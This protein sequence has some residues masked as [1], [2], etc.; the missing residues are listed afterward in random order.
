[1]KY[2]AG[3]EYSVE[4]CSSRWAL[5]PLLTDSPYANLRRC[6]FSNNLAC[7]RL[8]KARLHPNQENTE[9]ELDT[10]RLY[11]RTTLTPAYANLFKNNNYGRHDENE[12]ILFPLY[13]S[14][15]RRPYMWAAR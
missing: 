13:A 2:M 6:W 8:A 1:M 4:W 11:L 5:T 7:R 3:A 15:L 9:H 14:F 10:L 12:H